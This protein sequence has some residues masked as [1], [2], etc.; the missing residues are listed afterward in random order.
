MGINLYRKLFHITSGLIIYALSYKLPFF[1]LGLILVFLWIG[2][3]FFEV[4]RLFFYKALPL[5]SLWV[6]LL[7]KEEFTRLN[8]AWYFLAGLILSW[9]ILDLRSFQVI[10]LILT[11]ADPSASIAGNLIGR[12]KLKNNK[13]LEGTLAFFITSLLITYF[14]TGFFCFSMLLFCLFL[15]LTEFFTK[16]DNF[17]IPVVG[18]L[19]LKL[20]SFI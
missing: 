5:K 6:P 19:Y 1:I 9:A 2:L 20:L 17:W 13:T 14:H 15:S 3:S 16:R 11:I 7:K 18:S 8:D 4:F 10:V 12:K